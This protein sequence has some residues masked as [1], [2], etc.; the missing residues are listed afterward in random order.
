MKKLALF[1]TT[2]FIAGNGFCAEG[3]GTYFYV[4]AS[5][6]ISTVSMR[7]QYEE[8]EDD[9]LSQSGNSVD[10]EN[11]DQ[12]EYDSGYESDY[13]YEEDY[14]EEKENEEALRLKELLVLEKAQQEELKRIEEQEKAEKAL[15][16]QTE[17]L[18]R[19]REEN[20]QNKKL[21]MAAGS[22][23]CVAKFPKYIFI[24]MLNNWLAPKEEINIHTAVGSSSI[25]SL[26]CNT[27]KLNSMQIREKLVSTI[28]ISRT[29]AE[30]SSQ[31]LTGENFQLFYKKFP[32]I[33]E[34]SI[35]NCMNI[36]V[37]VLI[38]LATHYPDLK[39][40]NLKDAL[41]LSYA[42]LIP[43]K[44]LFP[45]LKV[46]SM[47]YED[48]GVAVK[49]NKLNLLKDIIATT[50]GFDCNASIFGNDVSRGVR[51]CTNETLLNL[52][53]ANGYHEIIEF[54]VE[55]N[56]VNLTEEE[57]ER[58]NKLAID[59]AIVNKHFEVVELLHER[60]N[61]SMKVERAAAEVRDD[62]MHRAPNSK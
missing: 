44:E 61:S 52:A 60:Y 47:P 16:K 9:N 20:M 28:D 22:I 59:F 19:I 55:K 6:L 41:R 25:G 46:I 13:I 3:G 51:I 54:L 42:D 36:T 12:E 15:R 29:K 56:K 18:K 33:K 35:E 43:F 31:I 45:N 48:A 26:P 50:P 39:I 27:K 32:K 57:Y 38:K 4:E 34:L 21:R 8:K 17:D 49:E 62:F 23:A 10:M 58:A 14:T 24:A 1:L 5:K 40:V 2:S 53:A 30:I 11:Q 7:D 37:D